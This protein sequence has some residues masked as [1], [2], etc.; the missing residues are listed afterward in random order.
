MERL[1]GIKISQSLRKKAKQ[2]SFAYI[3]TF[4]VLFY[5]SNSVETMIKFEY[6][7]VNN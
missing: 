5:A 2:G 7:A 6:R 1:L 3:K 4:K